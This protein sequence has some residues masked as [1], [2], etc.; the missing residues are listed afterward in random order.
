MK[1]YKFNS[2]QNF[3]VLKVALRGHR[4]SETRGSRPETQDPTP[5][6]DT[7]DPRPGTLLFFSET[8]DP[9]PDTQDPNILL[10][11]FFKKYNINTDQIYQVIIIEIIKDI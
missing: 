8:R 4:K 3:E 10:T 2:R 7:R 1:L 11:R 5:E 6:G 9:R